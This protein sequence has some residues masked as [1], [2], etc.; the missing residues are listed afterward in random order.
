LT[1]NQ[2]ETIKDFNFHFTKL[3]NQIPEVIRPHNQ[4]SLMHYYNTLPPSYRH[5]LEEKNENNLGSALQNFLEYEEQA[6]MTG[7]PLE[8]SSKQVDLTTVLQLVQDMN[9]IMIY[10]EKRVVTQ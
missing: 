3:Y 9:N 5:R 7:L 6:L 2:G 10:F 8:D 1:F 4:A